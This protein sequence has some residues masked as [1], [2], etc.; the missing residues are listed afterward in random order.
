MVIPFLNAH[1]NIQWKKI[2]FFNEFIN[3]Q[4]NSLIYVYQKTLLT[5]LLT[6]F[7]STAVM[8]FLL[9]A[10][11]SFSQSV[12]LLGKHLTLQTSSSGLYIQRELF[13]IYSNREVKKTGVKNE[14]IRLYLPWNEEKYLFFFKKS[15]MLPIK[16]ERWSN[17]RRWLIQDSA[18]FVSDPQWGGGLL[19]TGSND[20]TVPKSRPW[21][22]SL[23]QHCKV[24]K[25]FEHFRRQTYR[26]ALTCELIKHKEL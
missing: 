15:I 13:H 22:S 9:H 10:F 4:F 1:S 11:V 2:Q 8:Y 6:K 3:L 16:Q 17:H 19:V 5:T 23:H 26:T 18:G 7:V 20:R 25:E 12:W 14:K 21:K 24:L